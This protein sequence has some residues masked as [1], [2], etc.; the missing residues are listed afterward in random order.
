MEAIYRLGHGAKK[1]IVAVSKFTKL[2]SQRFFR[3][4]TPKLKEFWRTS[5]AV[6]SP[7]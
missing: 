1:N 7:S 3:A 4:Y 5:Y 6:V 2:S